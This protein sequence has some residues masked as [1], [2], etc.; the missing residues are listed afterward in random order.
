MT[1]LL[2]FAC[3]ERMKVDERLN[4]EGLNY[5]NNQPALLNFSRTQKK[6][7]NKRLHLSNPSKHS[8][9]TWT[10]LFCFY[11]MNVKTIYMSNPGVIITA[12]NN[13]SLHTK[14]PGHKFHF[15]YNY[16]I[17]SQNVFSLFQ[18][19]VYIANQN[20]ELNKRPFKIFFR[21]Y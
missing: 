16:Y 21:I 1:V 17:C 9:R 5:K 12:S 8:I 3:H 13:R 6:N 20:K 10:K 18:L 2:N 19:G 15:K 7:T 4:E 14:F 11:V